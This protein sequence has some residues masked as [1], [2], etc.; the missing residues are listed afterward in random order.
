MSNARLAVVGMLVSSVAAAQNLK[1]LPVPALAL[2]PAAPH[3]A[4]NG[5]PTTFKAIA[6]GGNGSYLVEWDFQGDG[7]YDF[8]ATRTNRYDL[9]TAFTYPNQATDVDFTARVRVTS[10]GQTVES[11]YPVHVYADVPLNPAAANAR[12]L[13]V[14]RNVAIDDGLWFLHNGMTRTGNEADPLFG[15]QLSGTLPTGGYQNL[16][17]GTALEVLGR[18]GRY[19]AFPSAYTGPMPDVLEN[20]RRWDTDPYAEDAARLVNG[21][22]T[23]I[24]VVTIAPADEVNL[25]GFYPEIATAPIPGTDDGIGLYIG[26]SP[27][28]QTNGP[29]VAALRGFAVSRLAGYVAQIGDS[30]RVLGRSF[31]FITQQFVDALVWAQNDGGSYPG[32]WYYTPN[33]NIDLLGEFE[34]GTLGAMQG[35]WVAEQWMRADGVIVPNFAKARLLSYIQQNINVCPQGGTG[36]T[37]M[38]GANGV[39]DFALSAAHLFALGWVG[40]NAFLT[41]DTRLAFPGYSGLTRGQ[42]RG[43]Y[44]SS[45]IFINAVFNT[46]SN[47]QNGWDTGFVE[48]GDFGR[49]DGLADHWSMLQWTRAARALEPELVLFGSND[50]ARLFS[51]YFINNQASDGGWNWILSTTLGNYT[52]SY[53]GPYFRATE[54]LLVLSP[55]EPQPLAL[56][57]SSTSTV[58]EGTSVIF[59]GGAGAPG[60]VTYAW[61][62]G[63]GDTRAGAS[64]EYA[65]PDDGTFDVTLTVTTPAGAASSHTQAITVTNAPPVVNAG[66]DLTV[67]EGDLAQLNASA[68]DPGT[69]DALSYAWTFGDGQV[70]NAL[71]ATHAWA[72]D[73]T[74][75]ATLTATDDDGASGSDSAT[76]IVRNLAP[77][78]TSTPGQVAVQGSAFEY[79]LS[80]IDPGT[81]DTHS[82]SAPVAPAGAVLTNC[83]LSWTPTRAE[84]IA[85]NAFTLCVTDDDAGQSCQSFQVVASPLPGNQPPTAPRL[86][87]PSVGSQVASLQPTLTVGNATDSDGDALSYEFQVSLGGTVVASQSGVAEGTGTTSW[88]VSPALEENLEY[89]WRARAVAAQGHGPWSDLGRFLVNTANSAPPEPAIVSPQNGTWVDSPTPTLAFLPAADADGDALVFDWEVA[90][91]ESF[92]SPTAFGADTEQTRV[93]LTAA[94]TEDA[95]YCWRVRADDGQAQSAW[96]HACFRVSASDGAPTVPVPVAPA[97]GAVVST[98]TPTFSWTGGVDPEG[99]PGTFEIDV[100]EGAAAIASLA[101][102][103]GST[104]ALAVPLVDGRTYRWRVRAVAGETSSA[105]SS[106]VEFQVQLPEQPSA[107]APEPSGC[108]CTSGGSAAL[109]PGLLMLSA[110]L[111]RRRVRRSNGR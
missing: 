4:Y 3:C 101:G 21:L 26:Y 15:G 12:Q 103:S 35:L 98:V 74:F 46:T 96:V 72:D 82:C 53:L 6:R 66:D 107:P 105:W 56:V 85:P 108:G 29:L 81:A 8:S 109:W 22:L 97:A 2:E 10:G 73:G 55:D 100:T 106:D 87:A 30:N 111:G 54:A 17:A 62:L 75:T 71:Q 80:F 102:V 50:H 104:A 18:N 83:T 77:T 52:D 76:V 64:F 27:G 94:L 7:T 9:S 19:P 92:D 43:F 48:A 99:Q 86:D 47:G 42:L 32:S 13:Q 39:C 89:T 60:P 110:L 91:N 23:Q 28:D 36:G 33:A 1:V 88:Q 90:P 95:R 68:V 41:A 63:N 45:L 51:G 57:S 16:N 49:V 37:Y 67:D 69:G 40:A 31:E 65:F 24:T 70:A 78:I 61:T 93:T 38:A 14:M 79:T 5:H 34:A 25:T 20:A 44:D 84:T 58:A 11:S 59:T